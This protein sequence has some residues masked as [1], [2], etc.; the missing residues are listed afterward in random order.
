[1]H[2]AGDEPAMAYETGTRRRMQG[3]PKKTYDAFPTG[4]DKACICPMRDLKEALAAVAS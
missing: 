3:C 4:K 1:M 2:R